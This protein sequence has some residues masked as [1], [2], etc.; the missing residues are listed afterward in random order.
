MTYEGG[1]TCSAVRYTVDGPLRDVLV[2]HCSDCVDCVGHAWAATAAYRRDLAL[3]EDE[4]LRWRRAPD[5]DH[6]AQR[7]RCYR[8]RTLVFW[9]APER[10]TVSFGVA[11]LDAP[12]SLVVGGHIWVSQDPGWELAADE[13]ELKIPVYPRGAPGGLRAPVL[14]W[15]D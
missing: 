13:L 9:D 10:D 14:R 8:C 6:G 3:R 4:G 15:V 2:C 11:T 1:C 7:G 5:S 12:P